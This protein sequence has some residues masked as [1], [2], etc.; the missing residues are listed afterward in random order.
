M[1]RLIVVTAL[2]ACCLF[3]PSLEA[4]RHRPKRYLYKETAVDMSARKNI[5]VGWV[6]LRPDDWALYGYASK[7]DWA[8]IVDGLN[9][10][11]ASSLRARW[12]P[13][14]IVTA[15]RN[16]ED[17]DTTG[18]DLYIKF[19]ASVDYG[20]YLLHVSMHFIDPKTGAEIGAIVGRP[21]FGNDWGFRQFLQA[22]LEEV[23]RKV[24][25]EVTGATTPE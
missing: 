22:A 2:L 8:A 12:L 7:E 15:A 11:F 18:Q 17:E 13:G 16:K 14:R 24:Q 23:G 3:P 9:G 4:R 6:D 1:N 20:N 19:D 10:S 5:F 25:V 21:Y